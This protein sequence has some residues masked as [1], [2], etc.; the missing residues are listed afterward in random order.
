[1]FSPASCFA[2]IWISVFGEVLSSNT[3]FVTEYE[4]SPLLNEADL[5]A[6]C[7]IDIVAHNARES[8]VKILDLIG[9]FF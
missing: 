6:T 4:S 9:N 1:M 8:N 2:R 7:A 5:M 3:V